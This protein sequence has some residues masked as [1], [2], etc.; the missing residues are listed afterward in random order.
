ML[1]TSIFSFSNNVFKW[2]LC[3]GRQ[4]MELCSKELIDNKILA[5]SKVKGIADDI[6]YV[7]RN[8]KFVYHWVVNIEG[9]GENVGY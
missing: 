2:P 9:E 4:R 7:T 5:L 3:C 8:I 6:F 1:V